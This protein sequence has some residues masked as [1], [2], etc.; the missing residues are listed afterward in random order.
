MPFH[1]NTN[2]HMYYL[3]TAFLFKFMLFHKKINMHMG[4]LFPFVLLFQ[5]LMINK[6]KNCMYPLFLFFKVLMFNKKYTNYI[7]LFFFIFQAATCQCTI[8]NMNK[9]RVIHMKIYKH[10]NYLFHLLYNYSIILDVNN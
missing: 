4:C 9:M 2:L 5:I 1:K 8:T 3:F 10:I 7:L 6:Y